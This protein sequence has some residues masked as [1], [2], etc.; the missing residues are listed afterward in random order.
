MLGVL[1]VGKTNYIV[2]GIYYLLE[3]FNFT[4]ASHIPF[5]CVCMHVYTDKEEFSPMCLQWLSSGDRIWDVIT[6][7]I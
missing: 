2:V 4:T 5:L 3:G 7:A 1:P 6:Y